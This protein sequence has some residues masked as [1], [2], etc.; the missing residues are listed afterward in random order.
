MS[1][2]AAEGASPVAGSGG[3]VR[4]LPRQLTWLLAWAV[5]F[6]DIGTSIYYVPGILYNTVGNLAPL[7][8]AMTTAGFVLLSIK[9]VEIT[10][11]NP[12]GG[13]VVAMATKAFTPRW[14]CLGGLLITVDYFLTSAISSTS[15]FYYLGSVFPAL[16]GY[17]PLLAAVGLLGLAAVNVIGIRESATLSLIMA[18]AALTT[19]LI[20]A[21]VVLVQLDG[22]SWSRLLGSFSGVGELGWKELVIGFSAAW[23]AF[24]GLES[25]SQLSPAM[26]EPLRRTAKWGMVAVLITIGLTAPLLTL[27]TVGLLPD[28][29]KATESERFLSELG[30]LYGGWPVMVAVVLTA[31]TLLLFAANTAIIGC[32]HVFLALAQRG[33][34]PSR[35]GKRNAKFGTPHVAIAIATLVPVAVIV[36]TQGNMQRLGEMYA[37]GLLGAFALDSVALDVIRWR[38]KLRGAMFWLGVATTGMVLTAWLVNLVEKQ[39]ATLFGGSITAIGMLV[40]VGVQQGWFTDAIYRIPK[41]A[42]RTEAAVE[43]AEKLAED[44]RD[45]VSLSQAVELKELYPSTTLMAIRGRNPRLVREAAARARGRGENA[46]YGLFVEERPGLLVGDSPS[47]P[48]EEAAA[49]LKAAMLEA[50]RHQVELIPIWTV[51]YNAAEAIARAAEALEVD[52]V[53]VGVSRRSAIYHLLRGHVV[54]GLTRRLPGDCHLILCN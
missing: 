36:V 5:V 8:V 49:I 2:N 14:G 46:L 47:K 27:F 54:K 3:T 11:R 32:Y 23:L 30:V 10:W 38:S 45:M 41:V 42:R 16:L 24:S 52:G 28:P 25:I 4:P 12:E 15:G 43:A 39:A 18:C 48:N 50:A 9:Y 20:V 13:G 31:T 37:F 44:A 40:A 53:M 22:E 29:I 33:F 19:D 35:I 17:V 34:L 6:C 7:F 21:A 51:S 26:R 1:A